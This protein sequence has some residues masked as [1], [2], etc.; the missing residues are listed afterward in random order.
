ME[1]QNNDALREGN[2]LNRKHA[3]ELSSLGAEVEAAR[4]EAALSAAQAAEAQKHVEQLQQLRGE[5]AS[6]LTI[7]NQV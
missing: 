1:S 4:Q 5:L 7:T 3:A 2:R 6:S